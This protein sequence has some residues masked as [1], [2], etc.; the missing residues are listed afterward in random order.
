MDSSCYS[1]SG[2]A[3]T[4]TYPVA[5]PAGATLLSWM[6]FSIC[7]ATEAWTHA[8]HERAMIDCRLLSSVANAHLSPLQSHLWIGQLV[9]N[10]PAIA[11]SAILFLP[12]EYKHSRS[13][14]PMH[15]KCVDGRIGSFFRS[16]RWLIKKEII[17]V[18]PALVSPMEC[19]FLLLIDPFSVQ[20]GHSP[21]TYC[22]FT[23]RD[24]ASITDY[25]Q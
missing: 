24:R 5:S 23:V 15:L 22:I 13:D 21:V 2:H 18:W 6:M 10:Q 8:P 19:L 16:T 14:S 25:I 17:N 12:S 7:R 9:N 4:Q 20:T 11:A 1:F 3:P